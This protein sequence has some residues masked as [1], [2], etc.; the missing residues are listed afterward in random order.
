MLVTKYG[1]EDE[2]V[3]SKPDERGEEMVLTLWTAKDGRRRGCGVERE[4]QKAG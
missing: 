3:W 1:A 4:A 2:D